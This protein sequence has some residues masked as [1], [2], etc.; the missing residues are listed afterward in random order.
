MIFSK[1]SPGL[2]LIGLCLSTVNQAVCLFHYY[3]GIDGIIP[4]CLKEK[5]E[6]GEPMYTFIAI[7]VKARERVNFDAVVDMQAR[8]HFVN[9]PLA[10]A[11]HP[12]HSCT[13]GAI[14][15]LN[16][17]YENQIGIVVSFGPE[18]QNLDQGG[19]LT[20]ISNRPAARKDVFD[21]LFRGNQSEN[22]LVS[23]FQFNF[24]I[25]P[26]ACSSSISTRI[27]YVND[28]T[29]R[30]RIFSCLWDEE[31][32]ELLER[33][34][35][36]TTKRPRIICK[37]HKGAQRL[38]CVSSLGLEAFEHMYANQAHQISIAEQ[39]LN[40]ERI[41]GDESTIDTENMVAPFWEKA[42]FLATMNT[43]YVPV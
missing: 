32:A 3:F 28:I 7:Q 31:L 43:L 12:S 40:P 22:G 15:D 4:A 42:S 39:L 23:G 13:C 21:N 6:N 10:E 14:D 9:C 35:T 17:I 26:F 8:L 27:T 5:R 1:T 20:L 19:Q 18:Y 2:L 11:Q 33:N 38:F 37:P 34:N 41:Y 29:S 16:E 25:S 36:Q 30:L 24:S